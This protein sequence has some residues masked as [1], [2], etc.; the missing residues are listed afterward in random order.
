MRITEPITMLTDYA[1]ALEA[2]CFAI[3]LWR[4]Q[5]I[6]KHSVVRLWGLAFAATATAAMVGGTC[7]GFT[8]YLPYPL[9]LALWKIVMASIGL[10]SSFMLL[11][12]VVSTVA[13]SMRLWLGMAIGLKLALYLGWL[14]THTNFA[15]AVIDYLLAMAM[16]FVLHLLAYSWGETKAGWMIGGIM[17]SGLAASVLL[18]QF[19]EYGLSSNDVYHLIQLVALYLFYRGVCSLAHSHSALA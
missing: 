7:H 1:I 5:A 15:V 6:A 10:A 14:T 13:K 3:A 8:A 12:T 11:A 4:M 19:T 16:V 2:G 18:T 17:V 9:A